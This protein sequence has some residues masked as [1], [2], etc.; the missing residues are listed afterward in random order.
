MFGTFIKTALKTTIGVPAALAADILT[1]GAATAVDDDGRLLTT[2]MC[3]S[4]DEDLRNTR[5]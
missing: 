4:I 5:N 3:D 2:R 1:C